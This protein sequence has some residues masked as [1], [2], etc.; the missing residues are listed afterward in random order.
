[1]IIRCS[2]EPSNTFLFIN[3]EAAESGKHEAMLVDA[4]ADAEVVKRACEKYDALVKYIVVTHAHYDHLTAFEELIKAFPEAETV[5]HE[6][7]L[8]SFE[9]VDANVSYLFE[10]SRVFPKCGKTVK[11]GDVIVLKSESGDVTF[12][13]LHTPGHT[14]GC[15]CLLDEKDK[16]M[17]TGDTVFADGG[18]GRTDFKGGDADTLYRS[19]KRLAGLPEDITILPGHGR[20]STI[21]EEL[22]YY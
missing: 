1:M 22:Y 8:E 13:V 18:I 3:D 2:T 10:D 14:P 16:L 12:K 5:C 7:E 20:P 6:D 19:L 9:D 11:E 15:I 4:S 21:A 17:F